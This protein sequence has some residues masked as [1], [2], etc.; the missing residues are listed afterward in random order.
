MGLDKTRMRNISSKKDRLIK[1][2]ISEISYVHSS[3]RDGS[4][5]FLNIGKYGQTTKKDSGQAGMTPI[6]RNIFFNFFTNEPKQ[7]YTA[8]R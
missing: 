6:F 4:G 5:I 7:L 8:S 2:F 1:G 3:A